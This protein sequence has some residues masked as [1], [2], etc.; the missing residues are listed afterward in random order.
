MLLRKLIG[1]RLAD[2]YAQ[3]AHAVVG[4]I[5]PIDFKRLI[6]EWHWKYV[7]GQRYKAQQGQWLTPV[8][9][10]QP[11][12]SNILA[13]YCAAIIQKSSPNET[14][15]IVELGG[16][17]GTN[18]NLILN[19]LN[20][21]NLTAN[22]TILD[23][24]PSLLELQKQ[25]L[26][27]NHHDVELKHINLINVAQGNVPLLSSSDQP[28]IVIALE[29]LDNLPHDKIRVRGSVMEEAHAVMDDTGVLTEVFEPLQDPLLQRVL[30]RAPTFGKRGSVSWVPTVACGVL[31]SL[32]QSRPQSHLLVADFDWLPP[33]DIPQSHSDSN[34]FTPA[35]RA[36][37]PADGEPLVTGMDDL[38]Y[39]SYLNA[40]PLCDILFPT[41]FLQLESFCKTL[42]T[43]SLVRTE[44]QSSFLQRVGPDQV[45]ATK[46]FLTG[47]TPLLHDF[48]NCSVLTVTNP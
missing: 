42:F 3:P 20:R 4:S 35:R 26:V 45:A 32:W 21:M 11:H 30:E 25:T 8:E 39:E 41:N 9:L 5:D 1:Q 16:G 24:S 7:H 2:Y 12:F 47:Y 14:V 34:T 23:A 22:Y 46:S 27:S 13:T 17:S 43:D 29:V 36:L 18:A 15:Q 38:D 37:R 6:G 40:P 44:K 31:E 33:P 28:T 10:F 19:E 48:E